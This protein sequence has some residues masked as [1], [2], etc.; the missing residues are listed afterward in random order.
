MDRTQGYRIIRPESENIHRR[1]QNVTANTTYAV[2]LMLVTA[3]A[4]GMSAV[5][6]KD[7]LIDWWM[8]AAECGVIALAAGYPLRKCLRLLISDR[9]YTVAKLIKK[10]QTGQ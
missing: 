7:T 5:L 9:I 3:A 1:T 8:P 6:Q 10:S 2:I 4:L